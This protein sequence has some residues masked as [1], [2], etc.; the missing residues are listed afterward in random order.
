MT[1]LLRQLFKFFKLLNSDTAT[2][3]LAWGMALGCVLGFSPFL[4]LQTFLVFAIC[5]IFRVQLGA[6]FFSAF[7][8]KIIAFLIDPLAD[9]LGKQVLES[10]MLRETFVTMYNMP[11]VPLTRFNNSIVMGS[12]IIGFALAIPLFFGFKF[13]IMK[14]RQNVVTK[15][16]DTKLW[17]LWTTTVFYKWYSHYDEL[18]G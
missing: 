7:F 2:Q 18:Y 10:P 5:F 6:A 13:F 9:I 17:K 1:L 16:K 15:F 11:L 4:S 14:Y 3:S 12:G 8:F